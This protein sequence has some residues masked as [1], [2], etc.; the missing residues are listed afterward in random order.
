MGSEI[1]II[2]GAILAVIIFIGIFVASVYKKVPQGYALIVNNLRAKPKVSFTGALVIPVVHKM[3]VMKISLITLEIDRRGKDGLICKDNLRADITVAFYLR[4]NETT[5]DVLKVAKAISVERASD[6]EAVNELFN[7][8]FS[9]ALKTVGKKMDF[10]ELFE[11]RIQFREKIVDVI[12]DDLNG[13]ALED[14]AID[15]LEQTPKSQLDPNNILDSEGIRRITEITAVQNVETNRLEKDEELAITK[16][17]VETKEALLALERQEEDATAKQ[18]RE[19][20]TIR[21]REQAETLKVE[22]EEKLKAEQARIASDEQIAI[23]E[24]NKMRQIE[25]AEQNRERAVV[26]EKEKVIRAQQM[27]AV[28]REREVELSIIDKDKALEEEKKIIAQTISERIAVEKKV[29]EEEERIKEVQEVSE[30][31]RQKQVKVLAAEASAQE[32]L[33]HTVKRAEAEEKKAEHKSREINMLAQAELEAAAKKSEAEKKIA[34]GTQATRAASGLAEAKVLEAKADAFEK[35]GFAQARVQEAKAASLQKEGLAEANVLEE[36][37]TAEA[38]GNEQLGKADAVAKREIGMSEADILRE[39][40]KAEADALV[41]KFA[42]MNNMS[43]DSREFEEFRMNLEYNLKEVL[44][45]IDANKEISGD[46]AEVLSAAL[47]NANIDIVGGQGDYFDKLA[48]GMG[49]G[50]AVNGF[51]E[52]SPI[53][54][55]LMEK[56]LGGASNKPEIIEPSKNEV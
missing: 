15:F 29:A 8:K 43:K 46:Q 17:N 37:L 12:G 56:L 22:A 24:E 34:E 40:G 35:E 7:A 1:F 32:E 52:K 39:K 19:I 51:I 18:Q 5:D 49:A 28:N 20:A 50:N 55:A 10:L 16:K 21:A 13:Y 27:E 54:Q 26:V 42:A 4:V 36:K 14:V 11:N 45:S 3:E 41:E 23:R 31:D 44:A 9:E 38:R 2:A 6:R 48:K 25:V 53:V 30:A 33:V 47:K